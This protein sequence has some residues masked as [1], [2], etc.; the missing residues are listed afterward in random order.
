MQTNVQRSA[1]LITTIVASVEGVK[2][3]GDTNTAVLSLENEGVPREAILGIY[4]DGNSTLKYHIEHDNTSALVA[5][6]D[7][8]VSYLSNVVES[9]ERDGYKATEER[10]LLHQLTT[11]LEGM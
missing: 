6:R 1:K 11:I 5:L 10:D 9:E 8:L 4:A 3:L 7:R 2:T